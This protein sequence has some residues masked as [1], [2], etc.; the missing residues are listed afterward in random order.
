MIGDIDFVFSHSAS[1]I[2]RSLIRYP[3]IPCD[4]QTHSY[5]LDILDHDDDLDQAISDI[6]WLPMIKPIGEV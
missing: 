3:K 1:I 2:N 5:V 6:M 4:D